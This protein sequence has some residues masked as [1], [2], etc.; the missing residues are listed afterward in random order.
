MSIGRKVVVSTIVSLSAAGSIFVSSAVAATAVQTATA[1][2]AAAP[3]TVFYH[4]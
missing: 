1:P 2:V 3:S 4:G